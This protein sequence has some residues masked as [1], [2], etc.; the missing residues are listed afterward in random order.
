MFG[1]RLF[2]GIGLEQHERIAIAV[3]DNSKDSQSFTA[4]VE[5]SCTTTAK[6]NT[7]QTEYFGNQN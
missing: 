5:P 1:I 2:A 4:T 6:H 7:K 3:T